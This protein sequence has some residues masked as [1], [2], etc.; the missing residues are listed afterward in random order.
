VDALEEITGATFSVVYI[1]R[2]GHVEDL[3]EV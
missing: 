1:G 2:T 3:G